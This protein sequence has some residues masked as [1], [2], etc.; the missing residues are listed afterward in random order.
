MK[1]LIILVIATVFIAGCV[2]M[3]YWPEPGKPTE[4]TSIPTTTIE[5]NVER[6]TIDYT[7]PTPTTIPGKPTT[8]IKQ[9]STVTT[10][11]GTPPTLPSSPFEHTEPFYDKVHSG[12]I[13]SPIP[14]DTEKLFEDPASYRNMTLEEYNQKWLELIEADVDRYCPDVDEDKKWDFIYEK[15]Y[16]ALMRQSAMQFTLSRPTASREQMEEHVRA[17]VPFEISDFEAIWT[18]VPSCANNEET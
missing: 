6:V 16:H 18:E 12:E 4:T 13:E 17:E 8:T 10:I 7:P 15:Y 9:T 14:K 5:E 1:K 3:L 2:D 11:P